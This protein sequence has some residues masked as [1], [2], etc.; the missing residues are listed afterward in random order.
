MAAR[1][2]V[3]EA[4][5]S[6]WQTHLAGAIAPEAGVEA[7]AR[8]LASGRRRVVVDTYDLVR[9]G[10]L[11]RRPVLTTAPAE[12][13]MA[14]T[15]RLATLAAAAG[16]ARP[17]LSSDHVAPGTDTERRIVAIWGELLG[18]EGIGIHDDFFELG[19]HSL[20][21]TRVL[22]RIGES[23]GVRL[24]LRDI[25]DAPTVQGLAARVSAGAQAGAARAAENDREELEF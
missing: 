23:L 2:Q 4:L 5:R 12:T 11:L 17:A 10:E 16:S 21:A 3:P 22:S 9:S 25:F 19:G 15:P 1:L 13:T 14:D 20:M 6:H 8:V 24:A 18:V 7:F